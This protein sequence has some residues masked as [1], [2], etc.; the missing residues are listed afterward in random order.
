MADGK[1][2]AGSAAEILDAVSA[3][4]HASHANEVKD[5]AAG[6]QADRA[7]PLIVASFVTVKHGAN[8]PEKRGALLAVRP[9]CEDSVPG[10]SVIRLNLGY[11]VTL[12]P[13]VT[14]TYTPN[15]DCAFDYRGLVQMPFV[16]DCTC[17]RELF[18][19]IYNLRKKRIC[20]PAL[21]ILG[22][23]TVS[24]STLAMCK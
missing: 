11:C 10:K 23:F 2:A 22:H 3:I 6:E 24:F 4:V 21:T 1:G 9:F 7:G 17:R 20:I 15:A 18:V 14:L 16:V 13:K 19:T 5:A 12:H 8:L